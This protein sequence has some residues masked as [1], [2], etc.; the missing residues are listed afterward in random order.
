MMLGFTTAADGLEGDN[1]DSL[2][3]SS[4]QAVVSLAGVSDMIN[5]YESVIGER[6]YLKDLL[7]GTPTEAIDRYR[8]ASPIS[9]LRKGCPPVLSIHGEFDEWVPYQQAVALDAKLEEVGSPHFGLNFDTGN[10]ARLLDDPIKA[11][12][13]VA[14]YT[15]ATHVKDLKVN[16]QASVDDWY[17]FSTAPVGDGFI[18]NL[19]LARLLKRAGFQGFLAVELDFLHPDYHADED[20]AVAKSIQNLKKIAAQAEAG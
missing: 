3:S 19:K 14:K 11:A 15:L 17:F 16:P 13:K 12:E 10:F 4:V 7:G 6:D 9:Y 8:S 2:Y 20:A 5:E 1:G 18:D